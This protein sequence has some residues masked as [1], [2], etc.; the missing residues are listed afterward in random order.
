MK[1]PFGEDSCT[2]IFERHLREVLC[3]AVSRLSESGL[4]TD[5]S[6]NTGNNCGPNGCL[7]GADGS[8]VAD[9]LN[10]DNR[11]L[12]LNPLSWWVWCILWPRKP[13]F[14]PDLLLASENFLNRCKMEVLELS[15]LAVGCSWWIQSLQ[16]QIQESFRI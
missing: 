9:D 6:A 4:A 5:A 14:D 2:V 7:T 12:F 13:K 15:R 10:R 11:L 3:E 8:I 1:S 16:C